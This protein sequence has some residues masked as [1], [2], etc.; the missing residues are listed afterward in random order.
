MDDKRE[1]F[2]EFTDFLALAAL[3]MAPAC[4]VAFFSLFFIRRW[5]LRLGLIDRPGLRKVHLAPTPLGGGVGVW[6]GV[7][8]TLGVATLFLL[9]PSLL[10]RLPFLPQVVRAQAVGA[11]LELARL[12]WIFLAGTVLMV[13]GLIDDRRNLHWGIRLGIEAIVAAAV[14]LLLKIRLT[15]FIDLAY[16]GTLVS[17]VL[18][19]LWIMTLINVFNMLDNMDGLSGGVA[20]IVGCMLAAAMWLTPDP[21]TSRPQIL[22]AAMLFV[23]SGSLLGFLGHNY[24]PARIFLGDAGAYFV[25][26]FLGVA[27][28]LATFTNYQEPKPHTLLVPLC[29]MAVPLYDLLTVLGLRLREK[30][31]PFAADRRHFSHRLVDLGLSKGQ[32]V[33][34]IYLVT[35]TCG[36]AALVLTRVN[37]FEAALVLCI[38]GCMLGLVAI[39]ESTG[40]WRGRGS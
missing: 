36:L 1:H 14:V 4:G 28:L 10:E 32:A 22:V 7:G 29:V 9:N 25:G 40:W 18:S 3:T 16:G 39:L 37:L 12:W 38:V 23:L 15:A 5:A 19:I 2:L 8:L 11:V 33:L 31:S 24:S 26:F 17:V 35:A 13:V 6:L 34:T 20:M 21:D 27:T 30:R